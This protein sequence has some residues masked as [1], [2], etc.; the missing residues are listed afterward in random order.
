MA[1]VYWAM[2]IPDTLYTVE[3]VRR[4][5]RIAIEQCSSADTPLM[6]RAATAAY[7]TMRRLW[8]DARHIRVL[9]GAGNNGGDAYLFAVLAHADGLRVDLHALGASAGDDAI[10]ARSAWAALGQPIR[11]IGE[12][13]RAGGADVVVDGLFGSGL[14][15]AIE[16][17]AAHLIDAL[18]ARGGATL[19]LDVPSGLA[20]DTGIA[21][22]P[23]LRAD[24]TICFVGWKRGLFTADATDLCGLLELATLGISDSAFATFE[25]D[26]RR[27]D[28]ASMHTLFPERKRNVNKGNFG[29]VLTIGGDMGMAGAVRLCAEAALRSGAGKISVATRID[30]IGALNAGCPELMARGVDGP[31]SIAGMLEQASAIALGPGL[32]QGAWGHA[33]WDAA[34]RTNVPVVIDADGLNLLAKFPCAL[35]ATSILTP[36]PGEAARLLGVDI[37]GVQRDRFAAARAIATRHAAT[38]V[39]KG[40]GTLIAGPDGRVAV[41]PYGNS[42][43]ASAGMGDVLTGI[44]AGLLAQGLS[45]WD[46]ATAGVV[47]HA[48]AGDLAAGDAP[49][50]LI[51]SDLFGPLRR[52][53]NGFDA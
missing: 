43:M 42:G 50:G 34:V 15:R 11:S 32:G 41:C 46:A 17:E 23:V 20:A 39:L 12:A 29:H 9:A 4:I 25:A 19:A 18:N 14:S 1:S 26:A 51:A 30:H 16:G 35:A 28:A 10:A 45:A 3:Q 21:T 53:L 13:I 33:L 48:R 47:V 44:I 31:Q 22:G 37:E 38:V 7:A 6:Q 36:H 52:L 5:D 8:P 24:A 2:M 40:A 27:L 49:R